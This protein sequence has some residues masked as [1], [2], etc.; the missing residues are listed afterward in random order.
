PNTRSCAR[1][2]HRER[3]RCGLSKALLSASARGRGGTGALPGGGVLAPARLAGRRDGPCRGTASLLDAAR[4]AVAVLRVLAPGPGA[5]SQRPHS[6]LV[7]GF[8]PEA[9][10]AVRQRSTM[11][12]RKTRFSEKPTCRPPQQAV[13]AKD[14]LVARHR[15]SKRAKTVAISDRLGRSNAPRAGHRGARGDVPRH[16]P[17]P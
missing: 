4:T 10:D 13:L 16:R 1:A 6:D 15:V 5:G 8:G 14:G 9:E 11:L 3:A 12:S 17:P 2:V 7:G